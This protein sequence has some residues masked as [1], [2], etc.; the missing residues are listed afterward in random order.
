MLCFH[1]RINRQLHRKAAWHNGVFGDHC[2]V[3]QNR[4]MP[5]ECAFFK[6][7]ALTMEYRQKQAGWCIYPLIFLPVDCI[8]VPSI[9]TKEIHACGN[10]LVII[11]A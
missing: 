2:L 5:L 10:F 6:K 7:E 8:A 1:C 3:G 9:D 11:I 4:K